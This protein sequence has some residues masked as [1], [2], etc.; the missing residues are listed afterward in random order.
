MVERDERQRPVLPYARPPA[1]KGFMGWLGR[2][3]GYVKAA[4]KS[5]PS[6][7]VYR[8]DRIEEANHP[9]QP[10]VTLRRTT[11]DEVVVVEEDRGG[12]AAAADTRPPAPPSSD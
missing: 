1:G 5:Q 11:I 7:V 12:G 10:G 9:D 8:A 4:I 3:V 6:R 2:Q